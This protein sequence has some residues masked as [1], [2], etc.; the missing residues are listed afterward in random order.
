MVKT[1]QQETEM[2]KVLYETFL[3]CKTAEDVKALLE[4]LCTYTETEQMAQRAK[5]A[6]LLK[7]G[8][9]Y[10]EVIAATNIS[11]AT[12]SRVSRCVRHGGGGYENLCRRRKRRI[13]KFFHFLP[14]CID[15]VSIMCYNEYTENRRDKQ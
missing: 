2:E 7:A 11:S 8:K 14:E 15:N 5:A 6:Q 12:L 1:Q 3:A 9:T 4:D 10:T 13:K